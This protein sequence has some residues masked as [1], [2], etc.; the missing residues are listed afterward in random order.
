MKATVCMRITGEFICE[1]EVDDLAPETIREA[2]DGRLKAPISVN[3][4]AS[5][6]R[7]LM[8]KPKMVSLSSFDNQCAHLFR[9]G[10]IKKGKI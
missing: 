2:A 5:K 4:L 8:L 9:V 10:A 3:C 6:A 1:V 7:A